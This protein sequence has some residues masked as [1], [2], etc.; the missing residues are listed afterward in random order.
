MRGATLK[1]RLFK[2]PYCWQ[3]VS[4]GLGP[5]DHYLSYREN[6]KLGLPIFAYTGLLD[7]NSTEIYEGDFLISLEENLY[8]KKHDVF[9]VIWNEITDQWNI[10]S[11]FGFISYT[12]PLNIFLVPNL[13]VLANGMASEG[14]VKKQSQMFLEDARVWK[15]IDEVVQL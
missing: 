8:F 10:I 5:H 13:I 1:F 4:L 9:K 3:I 2:E 7:R 11:Q 15:L 12:A 14:L 6:V